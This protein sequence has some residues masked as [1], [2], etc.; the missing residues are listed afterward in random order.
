MNQIVDGKIVLHYANADWIGVLARLGV[1]TPPGGE[2][3][4]PSVP[5]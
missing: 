3:P 1:I 2:I 4:R 5:K